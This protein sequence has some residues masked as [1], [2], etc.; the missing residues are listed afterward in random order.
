MMEVLGEHKKPTTKVPDLCQVCR[1]PLYCEHCEEHPT[2]K[3]FNKQSIE[4]LIRKATGGD[5]DGS[6]CKRLFRTRNMLLH[7]SP[8][9]K[10]EVETGKSM[11]DLVNELAIIAH[12][13]LIEFVETSVPMPDPNSLFEFI[14]ISDFTHGLLSMTAN[15]QCGPVDANYDE[16]RKQPLPQLSLKVG[17]RTAHTLVDKDQ[18]SS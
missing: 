8:A 15:M 4:I 9:P 12:Q 10:I 3:P 18:S 16:W 2:H 17:Q 1:S 13:S 7:G 5:E 14:Q 6:V 11:K